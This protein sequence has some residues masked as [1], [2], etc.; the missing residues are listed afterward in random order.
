M[1]RG[2]ELELSI[3]AKSIQGFELQ[4]LY[5]SCFEIPEA[6]VNLQRRALG[7]RS[8]AKRLFKGEAYS[9]F[10]LRYKMYQYSVP[11]TSILNPFWNPASEHAIAIL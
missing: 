1:K 3:K 7:K 5:S 11:V 8:V 6:T 4:N 9:P 2:G 10:R